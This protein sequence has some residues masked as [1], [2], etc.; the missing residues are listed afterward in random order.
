[1]VMNE[2]PRCRRSDAGITA[3]S[4][5]RADSFIFRCLPAIAG[6]TT[7]L[8]RLKEFYPFAIG[9]NSMKWRFPRKKHRN[10]YWRQKP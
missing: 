1:M 9:V 2:T 6:A 3:E 8:L 10:Q 5:L 7:T 4:R